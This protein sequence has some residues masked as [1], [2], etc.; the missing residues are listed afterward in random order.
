MEIIL[1]LALLYALSKW[2]IW[3]LS[4]L[5]VLLYYAELGFELPDAA[6]IQKYRIKVAM[7]S[8]HIKEDQN[9]SL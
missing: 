1:T 3:R 2:I 5:A 6:T 9:D 8:L 4:T 7:R